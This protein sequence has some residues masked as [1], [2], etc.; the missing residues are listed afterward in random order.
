MDISFINQ[1]LYELEYFTNKKRVSLLSPARQE[2]IWAAEKI[3]N[4]T[5]SPQMIFFLEYFN[6]GRIFEVTI[7]GVQPIGV[8]KIPKGLDIIE[9]NQ[10]LRTFYGWNSYWVEIGEDGF[11]NYYVI[12]TNRILGNGEY[13]IIFIDHEAMGEDNSS[14]EYAG[15][16]F[17]YV[18]KVIG[19]MKH[20]Y[21]PNGNLKNLKTN[22]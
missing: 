17:E 18:L 9:S 20:T 16:Y 15:G 6:G 21:S 14:I 11:G 2:D 10:I 8:R 1:F 12:D 13:P 3:L 5:L 19:E 7:K 22:R 4:C